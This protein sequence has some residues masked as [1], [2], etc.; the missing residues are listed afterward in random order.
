ML[1]SA[2]AVESTNS[3]IHQL[4]SELSKNIHFKGETTGKAKVMLAQEDKIVRKIRE[5]IKQ[6][7]V[8]SVLVEKNKLGQTPLMNASLRGYSKVVD[9]LLKHS[10]VRDN[11]NAVNSKGM[12]AWIYSNFAFFQAPWACNP[13]IFKH[14]F[15]WVPRLV[16]LPFYVTQ[17]ESPYKRIRQS[18]E[19]AG[20]KTDLES[21]K[22]IW[23]ETCDTK[24][25]IA[26][27]KIKKSNDLLLTVLELGVKRLKKATKD[28]L[29]RSAKNSSKAKLIH[30]VTKDSK[31]NV[32]NKPKKAVVSKNS[33]Y[34][35]VYRYYGIGDVELG[36]VT[37]SDVFKKYDSDYKVI[38]HNDYSMELK[39]EDL[40]I[41][42]YYLLKNKDKKIFSIHV[43]KPFLGKTPEG[44]V[45]GEST[46]KETIN[47]YGKA[48]WRSCS[49]SSD[50]WC[51][52]YPGILFYIERNKDLPR[53]P[54]N[55]KAHINEK[56]VGMSIT[57]Y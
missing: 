1:S 2:M 28:N 51:A 52:E 4:L 34:T 14:P 46:I 54:F 56:I 7:N 29:K 11:I 47:K 35:T 23:L 36:K 42:F 16:S 13:E 44:I 25:F 45:L 39:Y 53:F 17:A 8:Q 24:D 12:S 48:K 49:G 40:G 37:A 31:G 30:R 33:K 5:L 26:K 20:A 27:I 9:E 22:R 38:N 57:E 18:L 43:K 10:V 6:S 21:A 15:S 32:I 3:G 41:S 55:E 19:N 50:F